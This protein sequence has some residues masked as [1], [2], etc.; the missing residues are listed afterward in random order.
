MDNTLVIGL[1]IICIAY[2]LIWAIIIKSNKI[3]KK[4]D[5]TGITDARDIKKA[6]DL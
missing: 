4:I 1:S 5:E 6:L 2:A 3:I